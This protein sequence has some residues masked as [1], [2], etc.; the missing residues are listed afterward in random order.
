MNDD[1]TFVLHDSDYSQ[2]GSAIREQNI[3]LNVEHSF[4]TLSNRNKEYKNKSNYEKHNF[5]K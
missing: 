2:D 5:K 4:S 1:P 3:I